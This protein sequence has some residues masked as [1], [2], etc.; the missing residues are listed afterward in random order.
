M[1]REIAHRERMA[2]ELEIA[3][4]VQQ[5]LFP[6]EAPPVAGLD[7]AGKCRPAA[8]IG[9]DYYDFLP[10]AAGHFGFAIGDVSGK[11]IPAALLMA[12]LRASLRGLA[13]AYSGALA[14]LMADL[15]RLIFEASSAERYASFFYGVIDPASR[16]F[17]YVNAGHNP[18]L[19]LRAGGEDVLHLE[20]GGLMVGTFRSA[21]YQQ[22]SVTLLAGDTLVMFTDGISEAMNPAGEEFG[23]DRIIAA[24]RAAAGSGAAELVD[25]ILAA[26]D[27]FAAGAPQHDDMTLVAI[28]AL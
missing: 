26:V 24:A 9:G 19:L 6:Q 27:A 22:G 28:R 20:E 10:V 11:G 12:S 25:R 2:R 14:E 7:Y 15:N 21:R 17:H 5:R 23:E 3:R 1:A 8:T 18:P 4:D 13:I 16:A